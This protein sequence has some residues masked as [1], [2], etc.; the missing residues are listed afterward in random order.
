MQE[1]L[2]IMLLRALL[3]G[4]DYTAIW[5]DGNGC[6]LISRRKI[7]FSAAKKTACAFS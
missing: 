2:N 6:I 7:L 3:P 4:A 5:T 1:R